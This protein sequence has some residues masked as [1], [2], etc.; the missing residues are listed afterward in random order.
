MSA[1][2]KDGVWMFEQK[3][4][5]QSSF[6][7]PALPHEIPGYDGPMPEE[8]KRSGQPLTIV[9]AK[10]ADI[11]AAH[12]AKEPTPIKRGPGRPKAS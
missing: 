5:A 2:L 6:S 3:M 8:P 12:E 4:D 10:L 9:P 1:Y 11:Q 7:R